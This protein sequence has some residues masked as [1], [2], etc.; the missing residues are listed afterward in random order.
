MQ[1]HSNSLKQKQYD[2]DANVYV[3]CLPRNYSK[4]KLYKLFSKY[5]SVLRYKYVSPKDDSK[6]PYGF[7]QFSHPICAQQA[8]KCLNGYV[9]S[10]NANESIEVSIAAVG[11]KN[12]LFKSEEPTNLYIENMPNIWNNDILSSV[13]GK[14][15]NIIQSKITGNNVAFVRF[16]THT[17]ALNAINHLHKKNN[18]SV[19]FATC[20]HKENRKI[21]D[22]NN[23]NNNNN[24]YIKNLPLTYNQADLEKLFSQFGSISSATII[25]DTTKQGVAFVRF[26]YSENAKKAIKKLNGIK[27]IGCSKEIVVKY[28]HSDINIKQNKNKKKK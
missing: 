26:K 23:N 5:G 14:Y 2:P 17:Q 9:L 21:I 27:L 1:T 10:N 28:A 25:N 19:R 24:L 7:V 4:D 13:F 15:G 20:Q 16:E 8:I 6:C 11:R 3:C 18:M 22:N 12:A